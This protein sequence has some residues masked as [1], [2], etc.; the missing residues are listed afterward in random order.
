[1][2]EENQTGMNTVRQEMYTAGELWI[3]MGEGREELVLL[4]DLVFF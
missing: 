2:R 3:W 1:M 4:S